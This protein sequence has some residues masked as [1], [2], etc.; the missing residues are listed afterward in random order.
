MAETP[1]RG[2]TLV[3]QS[4]WWGVGG[5][6]YGWNMTL[7]WMYSG[8]IPAPQH[9]PLATDVKD[10]G[11][12]ERASAHLPQV[13]AWLWCRRG[14]LGRSGRRRW[15][16]VWSCSGR[17]GPHTPTSPV[18]QTHTVNTLVSRFKERCEPM[19]KE[20]FQTRQA[21]TRRTDPTTK[22][23]CVVFVAYTF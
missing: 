10:G 20:R 13:W 9:H 2:D 14:R 4:R 21:Q 22:C 11:G 5:G 3:A 1:E 19:S 16:A 12:S 6:I 8:G 7:R 15:V 18:T 17:P 23:A